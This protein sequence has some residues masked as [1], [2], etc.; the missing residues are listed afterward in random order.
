MTAEKPAL[1][2]GRVL[3]LHRWSIDNRVFRGAY[4]ETDYAA[5]IAFRDLGF[6][7]K[8]K[9]NCFAMAALRSADGAFLLGEMGQQTANAGAIYFAAGTPDRKD[10]KGDRVDLAGSVLREL[11]EETGLTE[12]DVTVEPGWTVVL[13]GGRIA[14]MRRV[15]SS[16]QAAV[17]EE[18]ISAF[19]AR[20]P[21]PEL[22]RMHV[23]RSE[24]DIPAARMPRFQQAYLRYEFARD[25]ESPPA[26]SP[27]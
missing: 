15:R 19:L 8:G 3:L 26:S 13:E 22:A 4:L 1:F 21:D 5:F 24:A 18:Q 10:V 23:V 14:L 11:G 25:R 17:L 6:P 9:H 16:L 27:G 12:Q 2:N 20:D 7:E